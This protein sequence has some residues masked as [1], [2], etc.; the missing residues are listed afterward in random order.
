M[1]RIDVY[2]RFPN[3]E[4]AEDRKHQLEREFPPMGYG[5]NVRVRSAA[6]FE[7]G[8]YIVEGYRYDTCD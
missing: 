2:E 5:T 8:C 4:K 1:P 7:K 6:D 3:K